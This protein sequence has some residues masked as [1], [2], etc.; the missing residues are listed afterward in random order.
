M[1][2]RIF[3]YVYCVC[4]SC[5]WHMIPAAALVA[6][7]SGFLY[8]RGGRVSVGV[9]DTLLD[10]ACSEVRE[11]EIERNLPPKDSYAIVRFATDALALDAMRRDI[12]FS[13]GQRGLLRRAFPC[14]HCES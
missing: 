5:V 7:L 3:V 10:N 1:C 4:K 11:W 14:F 13:T 12:V 8:N 9:G 2:V 6:K